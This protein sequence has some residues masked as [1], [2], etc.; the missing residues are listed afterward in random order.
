MFG[1]IE[2]ATQ[3]NELQYSVVCLSQTAEVFYLTYDDLVKTMNHNMRERMRNE[4][5]AKCVLLRNKYNSDINVN[6]KN[7]K[8]KENI[9]QGQSI[10]YCSRHDFTLNKNNNKNKHNLKYKFKTKTQHYRDKLMP[11]ILTKSCSMNF[12][13]NKSKKNSTEKIEPDKNVNK[14][15]AIQDYNTDCNNDNYDFNDASNRIQ[16]RKMAKCISDSNI[17]INSMRL[18]SNKISLPHFRNDSNRYYLSNWDKSGKTNFPSTNYFS[19]TVRN[20]Q[21]IM[22]NQKNQYIR[23]RIKLPLKKEEL[24]NKVAFNFFQS[25]MKSL[26]LEVNPLSVEFVNLE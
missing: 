23:T 21:D 20:N 10:Q 19:E 6:I 4:A 15:N 26:L 12:I 22:R 24:K 13:L 7:T 2:F 5:K 3:A 25:S 1:D 18:P 17:G 8:S 14:S 11:L 16:L 9:S